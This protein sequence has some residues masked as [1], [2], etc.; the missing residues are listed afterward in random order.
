MKMYWIFFYYQQI[1]KNI[2]RKILT[3]KQSRRFF[4]LLALLF[5][6]TIVSRFRIHW[7]KIF[8]Y[9][10]YPLISREAVRPLYLNNIGEI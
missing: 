2:Q 7:I 5:S 4:Y 3:D 8:S 1:I 10:S 6:I 9:Y